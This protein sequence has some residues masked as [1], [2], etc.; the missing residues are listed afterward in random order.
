MQYAQRK[1]E[2]HTILVVIS[3]GKKILDMG[4]S[5]TSFW[6]VKNVMCI[7]VNASCLCCAIYLHGEMGNHHSAL[8]C[9]SYESNDCIHDSY[10]ITVCV[11]LSLSL[12]LCLWWKW[13]V[14]NTHMVHWSSFR[15]SGLYFAQIFHFPTCGKDVKQTFWWDSYFC[16]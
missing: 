16:C 4:W 13:V 2:I 12:S 14:D 6:G 1:Q 15:T 9:F 8:C 3:L 5:N 7:T 11:F 10:T